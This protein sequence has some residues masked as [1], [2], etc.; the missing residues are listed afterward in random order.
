MITTIERSIISKDWLTLLFVTTFCLLVVTR[1]VFQ[2]KFTLF[3]GFLFSN[4][5]Q[6]QAIAKQESIINGF[7]SLLFCVQVISFSIFG[8]IAVT[9]FRPYLANAP[10]LFVKISS[11]MV[12]FIVIRYILEKIMAVIL[13][14]EL[15]INAYNFHK[16]NARNL[17]GLLLI[18]IN[19]VLVYYDYQHNI[20][21]FSVICVFV[22]YNLIVLFLLLKNYQKLIINKLFYFILYLCA[23]EI[24]PYLVI[25]KL[26]IE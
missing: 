8:Y 11:F 4:K 17:F 26:L 19:L 23:L 10:F 14:I 22:S 13:D 18:P 15:Y 12:F 21:F 6:S 3:L 9:F 20:V 7:T 2:K 5:Y 1:L 24:A 16:I 25:Y